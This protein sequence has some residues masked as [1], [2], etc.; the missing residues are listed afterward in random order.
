[1]NFRQRV[2]ERLGRTRALVRAGWCQYDSRRVVDGRQCYC[3]TGAVWAS[4]AAGDGDFS[5]DY[6]VVKAALA[7]LRR[8]ARAV[9]AGDLPKWNDTY[10]RTQGEVLAL[11]DKAIALA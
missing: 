6:R 10:G 3:L 4:A 8:A 1:M 2:R 5:H 7:F 9:V 11:I